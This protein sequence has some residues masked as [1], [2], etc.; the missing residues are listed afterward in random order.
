MTE[1]ADRHKQPGP[2]GGKPD[3]KSL[4]PW[5]IQ[6]VRDVLVFLAVLGLLWVGQ[7]TS[8]VTVPLLLAVLFAYL[9]EP[10]IVWTMRRLKI[11][12]RSAVIAIMVFVGAVVLVPAVVGASFGVVQLANFASRSV[13]SAAAVRAALALPLPPEAAPGAQDNNAPSGAEPVQEPPAQPAQTPDGKQDGKQDE[14]RHDRDDPAGVT[15]VWAEFAAAHNDNGIGQTWL[16]IY[17]QVRHSQK[18]DATLGSTLDAVIAWIDANREEIA[19]TAASFGAQT[20]SAVIGFVGT[21]FGMT[22][23]LFVTAF[24]FFFVATE[25]IKLKGF[26]EKLLPDRNRDLIVHLLGQFDRVIS[27]FIRGRLTIAFLQAFVFSIGYLIIGVPAAFIL[28][29]VVAVLSI[30]PYL[31]LVGVPVSILLLA[32]AP[33][34][35]ESLHAQ[36][37]WILGAP[38]VFYFIGQ[39][40]DDYVWTPMIQGRSTGMDTPT[41]L[42]ASLAGGALFGVFGL[43]I[44]IPIAACL[45]ILVQEVFWPRFKAWAEGREKDFLPISRE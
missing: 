42:F 27:G 10:V 29:P 31:A 1:K 43:L 34:H 32:L 6:W 24:F 38:T 45:K 5:Q 26:G 16:W 3:W 41:I 23:T 21:A 20:A 19:K 39:A 22:F 37:W 40:L 12:R 9:F 28:G 13:D 15:Q 7:K 33:S 14:K 17:D 4:H 18:E 2:G 44:A 35:A 25:W 30:V 36:W 11:K 8:V